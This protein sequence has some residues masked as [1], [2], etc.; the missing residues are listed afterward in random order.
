[1]NEDMSVITNILKGGDA[2]KPNFFTKTLNKIYDHK[3][4]KI[5]NIVILALFLIFTLMWIIAFIASIIHMFR[6][7]FHPISN[8]F[9][10]FWYVPRNI[11][12]YLIHIIKDDD[13][14]YKCDGYVKPESDKSK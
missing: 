13:F 4:F 12:S 10:F 5:V 8:A 7:S 14:E 11:F 3:I 1:M 2:F 9:Q 6:G